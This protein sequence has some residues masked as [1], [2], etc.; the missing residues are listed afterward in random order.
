MK[1][2]KIENSINMVSLNKDTNLMKIYLD[3][4]DYKFKE[5][6]NSEN[7]FYNNFKCIKFL[8]QFTDTFINNRNSNMITFS[9]SHINFLN[10]KGFN[11]NKFIISGR[12]SIGKSKMIEEITYNLKDYIKNN[13]QQKSNNSQLK[14]N[15]NLIIF[16]ED[17]SLFNNEDKC[18]K[19]KS[20]TNDNSSSNSTYKNENIN[21]KFYEK[22]SV[23]DDQNAGY[24]Y[25]TSYKN[26]NQCLSFEVFY[27]NDEIAQIYKIILSHIIHK[28]NDNHN[29]N[30]ISSKIT[31]IKNFLM[32]CFD[33]KELFKFD[34]FQNLDSMIKMIEIYTSI[35]FES[36]YSNNYAIISYLFGFS[37]QYYLTENKLRLNQFQSITRTNQSKEN[38]NVN[39]ND[40]NYN[41]SENDYKQTIDCNYN[42]NEENFINENIELNNSVLNYFKSKDAF[43]NKLRNEFSIDGNNLK[44]DF[45][46]TINHFLKRRKC[47]YYSKNSSIT[48]LL[49]NKFLV[50]ILIKE[51]E[52][53]ALTIDDIMNFINFNNCSKSNKNDINDNDN[54]NHDHKNNLMYLNLSTAKINSLKDI[55]ENLS[56]I[57]NHSIIIFIDESQ[58]ESKAEIFNVNLQSN[59][60]FFDFEIYDFSVGSFMFDCLSSSMINYLDDIN[61]ININNLHSIQTQT[62]ILTI[63]NK[64]TNKKGDK[65]NKKIEESGISISFSNLKKMDFNFRNILKSISSIDNDLLNNLNNFNSNNSCFTF[66]SRSQIKLKN[67]LINQMLK[68]GN[69]PLETKENFEYI[70]FTFYFSEFCNLIIN[71]KMSQFLE[72][73]ISTSQYNTFNMKGIKS[74][75]FDFINISAIHKVKLNKNEEELI[76]SKISKIKEIISG[77]SKDF[78]KSLI[79]LAYKENYELLRLVFLNLPEKSIFMTSNSNSNNVNISM[80]YLTGNQNEILAYVTDS[81]YKI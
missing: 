17:L 9:S 48:L 21:F 1:D 53:K 49:M 16:V 35:D 14:D 50:K 74:N 12:K 38:C 4:K 28:V 80:N 55:F 77:K 41:V 3:R 47:H 66:N 25:S 36:K 81:L 54:D 59:L 8:N 24:K 45:L 22:L 40:N 63:F 19:G 6:I 31:N 29:H 20:L 34:N 61:K 51:L 79:T 37:K 78:N 33:N 71:S 7:L 5:M 65:I 27:N 2:F 10:G 15:N 23:N 64:N 70:K 26:L 11:F 56:N 46:K 58:I 18:K 43:F 68:I 44:V 32:L 73:Q 30:N 39:E 13:S 52:I 57:K 69:N 62:Q 72:H 76:F 75:Y 60:N 42:T 67:Y